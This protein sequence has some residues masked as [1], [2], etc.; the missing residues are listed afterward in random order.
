MLYTR[1][2]GRRSN[3]LASYLEEWAR[4]YPEAQTKIERHRLRTSKAKHRT[5]SALIK[6]NRK[7]A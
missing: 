4:R 3:G 7:T 6:G 1:V 2:S 5:G